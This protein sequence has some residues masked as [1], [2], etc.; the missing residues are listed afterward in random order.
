MDLETELRRERR[1]ELAGE[2]T[3]YADVM[4]WREGELRFGRAITV[5]A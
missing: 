5:P 1:I 3:R 2:G 4:R